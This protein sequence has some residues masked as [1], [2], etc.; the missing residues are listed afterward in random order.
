MASAPAAETEYFPSRATDVAHA[1]LRSPL[2]RELEHEA[3]RRGAH[4]DT[5]T[6]EIITSAI[7]LGCVDQL[8]E[9]AKKLTSC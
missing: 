6:A 1:W 4:V 3:Q 9:Q 2:Y 5:L 8:L 7:V